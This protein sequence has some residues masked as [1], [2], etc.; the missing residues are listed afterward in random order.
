MTTANQNSRCQTCNGKGTVLTH[1]ME[2]LEECPSCKGSGGQLAAP[3]VVGSGAGLG[4]WSKYSVILS[5]KD[6]SEE[7]VATG[8]SYQEAKKLATDKEQEYRAA[9][10]ASG[11]HYSS[12]TADLYH[13]QKEA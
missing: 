11:K 6:H 10:E 2:Q 3:I 8:L 4:C 1:M 13:C 12:W 7:V 9:V 5:K